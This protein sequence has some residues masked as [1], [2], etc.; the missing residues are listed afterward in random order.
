V[1]YR[2]GVPYISGTHTRTL[3]NDVIFFGENITGK[4]RV[5]EPNF[6]IL[7]SDNNNSRAP[8]TGLRRVSRV[9][10]VE[11]LKPSFA[12]FFRQEEKYKKQIRTHNGAAGINKR[13][14][15]VGINHIIPL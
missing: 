5:T 15:N 8:V 14:N 2:R 7:I 11:K 6:T 10:H 13:G 4:T 3:S 1:F 9:V 12:S